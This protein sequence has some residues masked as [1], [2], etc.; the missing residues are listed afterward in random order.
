MGTDPADA[1]ARLFASWDSPTSPGVVWAATRDGHEVLSGAVGMADIAQGVK[2]DRRSVI[3]IGSQTKQFTVLLALMLEAQGKLSMDDEVHRYAPWL[4][5][6][7]A[8]VTLRHLA[9]NTSG[10]RDFLEIMAYGGVPLTTPASRARQRE[11][12]A[13]HGEVNFVPGSK[14]LYCNTGFWLLSEIIE[15]VS[16]RSYNELLAERITVP[17]GMADTRLL[18]RDTQILPRLTAQHI[19][20]PDGGWETARWGFEIGGEGGMVS[21][22]ADMLVWQRNLEL[23]KIGSTALFERMATP[24]TYT[25][26]AR[27]LYAMGLT[28][29]TYRGWTS[30]AHGGTVAGAKSESV[31]FPE[32][33]LGLV[34][35][36]N[37]DAIAPA[38]FNRRIADL[39]LPAGR[40]VPPAGGHAARLAA[41]AG[42]YRQ[43]G[44]PEVFAIADVGGAP[45]LVNGMGPAR[46]EETAPGVFAPERAIQHFT[47]ALQGDG[48]ID[49]LFCGEEQF[50]VKLSPPEAPFPDIAG[51]Y[52]N[53]ATGMWARVEATAAGTMLSIGTEAGRQMLRLVWIDRDLLAGAPLAAAKAWPP[54]WTCTLQ[55]RPEGLLLTTDRTKGLLLRRA[56]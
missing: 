37:F 20:Q 16:G 12:I 22:L 1:A 7:P 11:M 49:A 10:L 18:L 36:A 31:R 56:S 26:G 2:L 23:P 50:Y 4:P 15:D 40:W 43:E 6:Y 47:L 41:A 17:L 29:E 28:R 55:L 8:P 42:L 13:A 33:G 35:L 27:G 46:L 48:S 25:N 30:I 5:A 9:T 54:A 51:R 45:H 24:V 39:L 34:L 3:R 52:A 32:A 14:M 38:S 21:S 53:A 19:R 44:G